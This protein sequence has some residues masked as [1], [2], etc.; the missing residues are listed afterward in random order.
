LQP[1]SQA[2]QN[3]GPLGWTAFGGPCV[4]DIAHA[5]RLSCSSGQI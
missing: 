5:A 1:L 2:A 3:A 4:D